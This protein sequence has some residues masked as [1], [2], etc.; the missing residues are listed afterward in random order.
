MALLTWDGFDQFAGLADLQSRIGFL[1]WSDIAVPIFGNVSLTTGRD[2]AGQA[3]AITVADGV[4][5]GGA[6]A[7]NLPAA[8]VGLASVSRRLALP[9]RI[10]I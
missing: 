5:F 8:Q 4:Q 6:F 10:S 1:H 9:T 2:G 3:V 7:A